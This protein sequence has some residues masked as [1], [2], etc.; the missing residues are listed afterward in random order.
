MTLIAGMG[1]PQLLARFVLDTL[2]GSLG[3]RR[4][5]RRSR[6]GG[7]T[8][9]QIRGGKFGLDVRRPAPKRGLNAVVDRACSEGPG[10]RKRSET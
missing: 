5:A 7:R 1:G 2:S 8:M 3:L 10:G 4:H 6:H 9:G